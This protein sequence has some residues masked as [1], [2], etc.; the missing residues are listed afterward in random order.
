MYASAGKWEEAAKVRKLMRDRGIRKNP[1]C[2]WIELGRI[3]HVFVAND[4]SHPRIKEV[5]QFLESLSEKM[6]L[7]GYVPD[8]RWALA[9]DQAAE[10]EIR[11]Q[12]HSEKLAL[13][14]ALIST[15]EGEPILVMKNLRICG[16]CH[17]AIKIISAVTSREITV[18]DA[19]RF[20]CF[21]DGSCSCGD[22]W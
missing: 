18:R 21:T 4:V 20:H 9:K 7:A 11:L 2:S 6:A 16:D 13:A 15:K 19:H 3:V 5:Y 22:Y 12:H 17:N 10:G 1:G 8:V 14:F